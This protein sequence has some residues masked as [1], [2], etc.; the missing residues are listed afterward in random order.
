M[1]KQLLHVCRQLLSSETESELRRTVRRWIRRIKTRDYE[2]L[3]RS[4]RVHCGRIECSRLRGQVK[5][6]AEILEDR[7]A[8]TSSED[9]ESSDEEPYFKMDRLVGIRFAPN[10][11][12]LYLVRWAG[13]GPEDDTWEPR[14]KLIEDGCKDRIKRFHAELRKHA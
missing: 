7:L 1:H 12:V 8:S 9:D 4:M 2:W 13:F 3:A 10:N 5:A 11:E 14:D 6:M